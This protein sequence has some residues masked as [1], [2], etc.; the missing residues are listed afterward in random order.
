MSKWVLEQIKPE[1]SPKAKI[2]K[3]KFEHIMRRQ[4]CL[5]KTVLLEKITGSRK[6]GR[7]NVSWIGSTKETR[8]MNLQVLSR[9]V[10]DRTLW[11]SLIHRVIRRW[12][13]LNST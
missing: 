11:L 5:G 7:P 3:L 8:G 2:T 12:S 1:T 4:G 10:E 6:R 9:A 13:P